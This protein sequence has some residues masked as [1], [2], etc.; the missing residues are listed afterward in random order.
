MKNSE[1][2]EVLNEISAL[3]QLLN[4]NKFKIKA[5]A[6]AAQKVTDLPEDIAEVAKGGEKELLKL[7]GI[8]KGIADKIMEY[9][10][11]GRVGYIDELTN[12]VPAG[13]L[14]ILKIP[15]MGPKR[16]KLVYD[17]LGIQSVDELYNALKN[18]KFDGFPGFKEKM[19]SNI[20]QGI[21]LRKDAGKRLLLSDAL[22]LAEQVVKVLSNID[23]VLKVEYAGSLRRRKETIGDIDILC[24]VEQGRSKDVVDVFTALPVVKSVIA[25]GDTKVSVLTSNNVQ[26]DLRM[27]GLDSFGAALQYFT[28]SKEHNVV[29]REYAVKNGFTLNEYGLFKAG[30]KSVKLAAK[31]EDDVYKALGMDYISPV[32]RENRSEI[33][34]AL[35][36]KLPVLVEPGDIKGDFHVHSVYSDGKNS[37]MDIALEAVKLGYKWVVI[38]D[39]SKSL[40]IANGL[41]VKDIERKL[42][43]I[44]KTNE[45]IGDKIRVFS[46]TEVDILSD[47]TLDYPDDVLKQFEFVIAA[48][49]TGFQQSEEQITTRILGAMGNKYV[50]SISHPTG[51]LLGQRLA[52]NVDMEKLMV[53]A[54]STG[55]WL[56]LNA[57]PYRLDINDIFC[58][59]AKE[60]GVRVTIGSDAHSLEQ[61]EYLGLG[62]S[63]AQRG[64]LEVNDVV[65]TMTAAELK[66]SFKSKK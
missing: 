1:V 20:L 7:D 37:V 30:N 39:H 3:L 23:A 28:G 26:M 29:L 58:M 38:T 13:L 46:G 15:G 36:H 17:K 12:K 57:N 49:H 2:T 25:T 52:Y 27:V 43:E 6:V 16:T 60:L 61:L 24:S 66:D 51:R 54:K 42:K 18:K 22:E 31:N 44:D 9:L 50:N 33:I 62:L 34:S 10:N 59:R 45:K 41:L 63:T 53:S 35:T 47:G 14:E 11:T 48:I 55:T 8:G 5:Y 4:E 56:E 21:E 32:L 19:V 65:N 40:R 64:W